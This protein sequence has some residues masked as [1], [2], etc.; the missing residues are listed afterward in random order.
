MLILYTISDP[1]ITRL[2]GHCILIEALKYS[3][4]LVKVLV[5]GTQALIVLVKLLTAL[6]SCTPLI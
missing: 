2:H 3:Q 1:Y 6:K 4:S 5:I